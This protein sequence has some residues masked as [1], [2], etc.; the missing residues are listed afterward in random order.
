VKELRNLV[1]AKMQH[2]LQRLGIPLEATWIPETGNG[3]HGEIKS[4]CL[5]VYDIDEEQ[6]WSTFEHEVF[7]FKL[8][9]VTLVYRTI[10]NSLIESFEKLHYERKERFLELLP[11]LHAV[12]AEEKAKEN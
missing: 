11:S 7:E 6:A 8:N 4:G 9:E 2:C 5:F 12:V 1:E 3:K 10:I